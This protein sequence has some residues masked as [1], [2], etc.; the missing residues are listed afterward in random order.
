MALSVFDDKSKQPSEADLARALGGSLVFWNELKKRIESRFTPLTFEWG[1]HQ[2]NNWLGTTPRAQVADHSL[3]DA[4]RRTFS[5]F[6]LAGRQGCR[7]G[8]QGQLAGLKFFGSGGAEC[9]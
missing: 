5:G 1:F 4:L 6:L 3:H 7:G 2:Q 9:L 8:A